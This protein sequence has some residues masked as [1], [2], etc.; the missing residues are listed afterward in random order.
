MKNSGW[1]VEQVLTYGTLDPYTL[2]WMSRMEQQ[3]IN[4][5]DSM[6]QRFIGYVAGMVLNAPIY[7]LQKLFSM[8]FMTVVARPA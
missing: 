8:G 4:W 1:K 6:E 3:S 5:S 7:K 2:H